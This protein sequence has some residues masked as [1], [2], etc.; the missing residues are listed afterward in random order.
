MNTIGTGPKLISSLD[1]GKV[2][3]T[4][5]RIERLRSHS[6][7]DVDEHFRVYGLPVVSLRS[8][9]YGNDAGYHYRTIIGVATYRTTKHHV[10]WWY[11]FGWKNR[12]WTRSY[13][14]NWYY[15]H[16]AGVDSKGWYNYYVDGDKK[17]GNFWERSGLPCQRRL[18]LVKHK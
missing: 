9:W 4:K 10:I 18:G 6:W 3:H 7:T 11:W 12:R 16:D 8:G 5:Y 15:M 13:D 2:Y 17:F 1:Y 14:T